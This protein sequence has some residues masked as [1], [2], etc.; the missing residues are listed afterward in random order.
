VQIGR[1]IRLAISS[2]L[3]LALVAGLAMA[4]LPKRS[5]EL[6]HG[7]YVLTVSLPGAA[8]GSVLATRTIVI[9]A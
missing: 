8:Q 5:L 3:G 7:K 2:V 6:G 4:G 1:R 9:H